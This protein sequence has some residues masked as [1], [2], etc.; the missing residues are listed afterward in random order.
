MNTYSSREIVH[1]LKSICSVVCCT[2]HLLSANP[3]REDREQLLD[4]LQRN[5]KNLSITLHHIEFLP[6]E[7]MCFIFSQTE[8]EISELIQML[9]AV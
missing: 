3:T 8:T 7:D 5:I 9:E 4:I 1:D 2:L 6:V